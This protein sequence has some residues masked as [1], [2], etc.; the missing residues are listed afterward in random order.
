MKT[1]QKIYTDEERQLKR[2][3]YTVAA[4]FIIAV[5][6]TVYLGTL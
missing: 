5:L 1:T 6:T 3:G 4:L 2:K